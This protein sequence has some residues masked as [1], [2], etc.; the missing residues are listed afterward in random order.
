MELNVAAYG[1]RVQALFAEAGDRTSGLVASA[2]PSPNLNDAISLDLFAGSAHPAGALSGL[3][4]YFDCFEKAHTVAQEDKSREG[5]FWHAIA[6]RREPDY[7]NSSYWFQQVG[8]HPVYPAIL[9]AAKQLSQAMPDARFLKGNESKWIP[10]AFV[11]YCEE[12]ARA[13][14]VREQFAVRMQ[15]AEWE[16]LFDYCASAGKRSV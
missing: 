9:E 14:G 8:N 5:S 10:D 11:G 12:A 7:F 15:R 4:L 16:I 2:T 13:G 1:P 6:H 3:W